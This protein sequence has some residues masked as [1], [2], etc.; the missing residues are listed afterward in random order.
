MQAQHQQFRQTA[1]AQHERSQASLKEMQTQLQSL[2]NQRNAAREAQS[3]AAYTAEQTVTQ[4]MTDM[5]HH[6]VSQALATSS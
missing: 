2:E 4:A 6:R 1:E 3:E 5:G